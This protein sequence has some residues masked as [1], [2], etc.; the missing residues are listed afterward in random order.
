MEKE[1]VLQAQSKGLLWKLLQ[2]KWKLQLRFIRDI[3]LLS[4]GQTGP[5]CFLSSSERCPGAAGSNPIPRLGE[6]FMFKGL[7]IHN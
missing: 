1:K 4:Q 7:C 5:T 3:L 2:A 6:W